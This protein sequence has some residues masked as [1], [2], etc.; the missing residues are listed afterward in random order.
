MSQLY[1]NPLDLVQKFK[2]YSTPKK[3]LKIQKI[4]S[5]EFKLQASTEILSHQVN[6]FNCF[7]HIS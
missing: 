4:Y 3:L 7:L 5:T 6:I 2:T 1:E